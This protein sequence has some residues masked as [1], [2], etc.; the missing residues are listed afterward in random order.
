MTMTVKRARDGGDQR[1]HARGFFRAHAGGRLVEQEHARLAGERE[2]DFELALAAVADV[3]DRGCPS[4]SASPTRA[5]DRVGLRVH[6]GRR[7]ASAARR[8]GAR[9]SRSAQASAR[10]SRTVKSGNRLLRWNDRAMPMRARLVTSSAVTSRP[11]KQHGA[12]IRPQVAG[13]Q[14]E[15]GG[16]AGAIRAD[17]GVAPAR[18]EGEADVLRDGSEPNDLLSERVSSAITTRPPDR[19]RPALRRACADDR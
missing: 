13:E 2:R 17:D 9:P 19:R 8:R 1:M 5:G 16:L 6:R 12:A 3:A 10:L 7:C 15:I 18:L 11:S 14:V 4:M